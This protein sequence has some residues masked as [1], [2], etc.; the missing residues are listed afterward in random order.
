MTKE[1]LV[2]FLK[3]NLTVNIETSRDD[4][5]SGCRVEVSLSLDGEI[6]S[7]TSDT[8]DISSVSHRYEG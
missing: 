4:F 1:E 8:V 5:G 2:S 7:E 6:I 3:E